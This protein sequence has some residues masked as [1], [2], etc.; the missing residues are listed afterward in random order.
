M[1]LETH[2]FASL[3]Y[4][5]KSWTTRSECKIRRNNL[6]FYEF[7]HTLR[8]VRAHC[9]VHTMVAQNIFHNWLQSVIVQR[10]RKGEKVGLKI[11]ESFLWFTHTTNENRN[12][13]SEGSF[14]FQCNLRTEPKLYLA[15]GFLWESF[16]VRGEFRFGLEYRKSGRVKSV[17]DV[18]GGVW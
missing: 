3:D 7:F 12:C 1:Y 13:E 4:F 2:L 5:S 15:V 14:P 6:H 8:S 11:G 9:K 16:R 18:A 10:W 17:K